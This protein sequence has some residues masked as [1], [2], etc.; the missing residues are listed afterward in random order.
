ASSGS[1]G[2]ERSL[3]SPDPAEEGAVLVLRSLPAQG[4]TVSR[5]ARHVRAL[6]PRYPWAP[7]VPYVLLVA[8]WAS[9]K[10]LRREHLAMAV[11]ATPLAYGSRRTKTLFVAA[12]PLSAVAVLYDAMRLMKNTGMSTAKVHVGDIRAAE[13]K[14]FGVGSGSN[15]KTLQDWFYE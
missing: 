10:R 3:G 5:W 12:L 15:R 6:W 4:N 2:R 8:F 13:L 14:W 7:A 9:K 11:A 1:C